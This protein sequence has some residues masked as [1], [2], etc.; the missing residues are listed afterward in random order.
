MGA[1]MANL[2]SGFELRERRERW[3]AIRKD[4]E[5]GLT[6]RVC[7]HRGGRARSWDV[8]FKTVMDARRGPRV[9]PETSKAL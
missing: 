5:D 4:R 1:G 8:P 6:P 3:S 9:A 2:W 7:P